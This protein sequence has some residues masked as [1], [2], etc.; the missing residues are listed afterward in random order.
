MCENENNDDFVQVASMYQAQTNLLGGLGSVSEK[1]G[2][3]AHIN[4]F[5]EVS[6]ILKGRE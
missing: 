1:I 3:I 2:L 5:A 6:R 4:T